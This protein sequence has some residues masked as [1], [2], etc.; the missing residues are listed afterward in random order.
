M[1]SSSLEMNAMLAP[2]MR[3]LQ[4][5]DEPLSTQDV[6]R[7]PASVDG[8]PRYL[9]PPYPAL[10]ALYPRAHATCPRLLPPCHP[11]L[12]PV[13]ATRQTKLATS[14]HVRREPARGPRRESAA[15]TNS[16]GA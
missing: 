3:G 1:A 16:R 8:Y 11:Q 9:S 6:D 4:R 10:S 7:Y 2:S 13:A 15:P 5:P 12:K 14:P